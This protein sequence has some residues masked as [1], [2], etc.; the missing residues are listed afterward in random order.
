MTNPL[1]I[2]ES[3]GLTDEPPGSLMVMTFNRSAGY[4]FFTG[5]GAASLFAA[6]LHEMGGD[7]EHA[8]DLWRGIAVPERLAEAVTLTDKHAATIFDLRRSR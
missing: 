2:V 5:F 8:L 6:C 7:P 1:L 4:G 3:P